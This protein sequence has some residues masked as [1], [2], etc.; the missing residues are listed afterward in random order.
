MRLQSF[1]STNA[2]FIS[3]FIWSLLVHHSLKFFQHLL[4]ELI[5]GIKYSCEL[6]HYLYNNLSLNST[7]GIRAKAVVEKKLKCSHEKEK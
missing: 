1:T 6:V 4:N 5:F 3:H 2:F 7:I